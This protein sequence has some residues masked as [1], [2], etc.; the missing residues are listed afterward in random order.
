[1]RKRQAL[2]L[3][4]IFCLLMG[5][6]LI[7]RHV[8]VDGEGRWRDPL[9]LDSLLPA[10]VVAVEEPPPPTGPFDVNAAPADTLRFLPG[11]GPKL[12]ARIVAARDEGGPF[13]DLEDLQRVKGI[14]PKLALKLAP[15]VV[16][17]PS[18]PIDSQLP[19][20]PAD[21]HEDT[22]GPGPE[23]TAQDRDAPP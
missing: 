2:G 17:G 6:R 12:A 19:T 10:P 4:L 23:T 22:M 13:R 3:V 9:W 21:D 7:R 18:Q 1:M 15:H 11:I 5:G 20:A 14:G 16:F 8:L